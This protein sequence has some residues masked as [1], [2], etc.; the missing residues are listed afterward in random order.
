MSRVQYFAE[1]RSSRIHR[2]SIAQRVLPE[3]QRES[4]PIISPCNSCRHTRRCE[5]ESLA[6][7]AFVLFKRCSPSPERWSRAPRLPSRDLYERA[8]QPVVK[9]P[10]RTARANEEG[11]EREPEIAFEDDE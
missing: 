3:T 8:M 7:Q 1:G 9:R 10:E 4:S 11:I 6:C 2:S 5:S